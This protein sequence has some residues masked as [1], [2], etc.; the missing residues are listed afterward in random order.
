MDLMAGPPA[1]IVDHESTSKRM[2]CA[3]DGRAGRTCVPGDSGALAPALSRLP[4]LLS[5][6]RKR[7]HRMQFRTSWSNSE[8]STRRPR[9]RRTMDHPNGSLSPSPLS[10]FLQQ[11]TCCSHPQGMHL[12][13]QPFVPQIPSAPPPTGYRDGT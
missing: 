3:K 8:N 4:E 7:R 6:Q 9:Q 1:A 5:R 11:P 13:I 12:S 10:S 2:P